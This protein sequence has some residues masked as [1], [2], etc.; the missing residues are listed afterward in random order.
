MSHVHTLA[1]P[2]WADEKARPAAVPSASVPLMRAAFAEPRA[3]DAPD[4]ETFATTAS[5]LADAAIM[6]E[7]GEG[8]YA[9]ST[10][11]EQHARSLW[12]AAEAYA[13]QAH[14]DALL[15]LGLVR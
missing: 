7:L 4:P 2:I 6:C 1:T 8:R 15:A 11:N 3:G 12:R 5:D 9:E 10:N 14:A 13:R